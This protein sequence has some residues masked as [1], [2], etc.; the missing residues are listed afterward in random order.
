M[1]VP[2]CSVPLFAAWLG[3]SSTLF[4]QAPAADPLPVVPPAV[5][6][7]ALLQTRPIP[8]ADVDALA[9]AIDRFIDRR[10]QAEK[11]AASPLASDA[12]FLRRAY[13][14]LTGKVPPL[15]K[16]A[17]FLDNPSVDKRVKL[18]DELLDSPE[19]GRH[20]ADRWQAVLLPRNSEN[21]ALPLDVFT[22]WLAGLFNSGTPWDQIARDLVTVTGDSSEK[23]AVIFFLANRE[24]DKITDNVSRAF[25]GVQLQ[26]AQC[27][28]HPF[29]EWKQDAYWG[30]AAFFKQ[31]RFQGNPR[32]AA[33][34]GVAVE[35]HEGGRGRPLMIPDSAKTEQ[36]RVLG[37]PKPP[38]DPSK[39]LRPVLANWLTS[40]Q[41]PWFARAMVN[42]VWGQLFGRGIVN[43]IDDMHDGNAPSHSE[44][45]REL[46]NQ[47]AGHRFD[48]KFLYR[49]LCNSSAYQRTSKPTSANVEAGPEL[50]ARMAIKP[51]TPEQ[52][53]DSLITVL[54]V[55]PGEGRMG[56]RQQPPALRGPN[57]NPRNFFV[58]FFQ[59][60]DGGD[61]TEY[62]AGIPQVLRLMN[63]P[64]LNRGMAL[65]AAIRIDATPQDVITSLYLTT[66]ARRPTVTELDRMREHFAGQ[67]FQP[68][69]AYADMLWA[70]LNSSEFALNH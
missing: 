20:L 58:A 23:P 8:R 52:L 37:G 44:L 53:Y 63:G 36:P 34:R 22:G 50:F 26:C 67:R 60:E 45:L 7:S 47:F 27:H 65:H 56:R 30:M 46:T 48:I 12:E 70:L 15:D 25:L 24:L 62:S 38:V 9:R 64:L 3:V 18:I 39:P 33:R 11:V 29:T 51:L 2:R 14:D 68:R 49:A 21:R 19:F 1:S 43:P 6:P 59:N 31:V 4:A 5:A 55:T 42:R 28:N 35:L 41:N 16:V 32:M 40:E 54:G 10:L 69:Q 66:L 57:A 61:A 17:A 13:L